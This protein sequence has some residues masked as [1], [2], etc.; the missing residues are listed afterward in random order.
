MPRPHELRVGYEC[1]S[2][3][4]RHWSILEVCQ[5]HGGAGQHQL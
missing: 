5:W 3:S 4:A 1:G 2:H